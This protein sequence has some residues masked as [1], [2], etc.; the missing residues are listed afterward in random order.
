MMI[1]VDGSCSCGIECPAEPGDCNALGCAGGLS[2]LE[3]GFAG[4]TTEP[5]HSSKHA[6]K[7]A[8]KHVYRMADAARLAA[9]LLQ[10]RKSEAVNPAPELLQV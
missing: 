5:R 6:S 9:A 4:S 2:V 3:S 7:H 1:S 8:S 10:P